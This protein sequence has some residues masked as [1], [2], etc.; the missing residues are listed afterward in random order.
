MSPSCRLEG[1]LERC[2]PRR[3]ASG[4]RFAL[5]YC[6]NGSGERPFTDRSSPECGWEGE[7]ESS[8]TTA[9]FTVTARY[10]RG[11]TG[12]FAVVSGFGPTVE[13]AGRTPTSEPSSRGACVPPARFVTLARSARSRAACGGAR[14]IGRCRRRAILARAWILRA[15]RSTPRR[16]SRVAPPPGVARLTHPPQV[17]RVPTPGSRRIGI[18][19]R[20]RR[21]AHDLLTITQGAGDGERDA[22][23]KLTS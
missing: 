4:M 8:A 14:T 1:S 7:D 16:T 22:R 17:R 21:V 12:R 9:S 20:S 11:F 18:Q 19:S 23:W 5:S 3:M 10:E 2:L 15:D 13:G 6:G